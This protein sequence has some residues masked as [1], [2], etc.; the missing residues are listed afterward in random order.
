MLQ[1]AKMARRQLLAR[2]TDEPTRDV[3]LHVTAA[4]AVV[5]LLGCLPCALIAGKDRRKW[6]PRVVARTLFSFKWRE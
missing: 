6:A 4:A 5:V 3:T 2:A 1:V